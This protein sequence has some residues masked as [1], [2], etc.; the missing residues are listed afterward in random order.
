MV[1]FQAIPALVAGDAQGEAVFG[2]EFFELGHDAGGYDGGTFGV[3]AVHHCGE[4][5][6]VVLDGV[7]E[8][9]CVD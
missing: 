8:E 7:G 6:E 2:A 4:E 1:A 9:V 3:E 5:V